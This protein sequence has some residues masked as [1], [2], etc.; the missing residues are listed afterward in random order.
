MFFKE[1]IRGTRLKYQINNRVPTDN[2][3]FF[4]KYRKHKKSISIESIN[5]SFNY[6]KKDIRRYMPIS[7]DNQKEAIELFNSNKNNIPIFEIEDDDIEYDIK[8]P[9]I[10]YDSFYIATNIDKII[11]NELYGI[12]GFF[13]NRVDDDNLIVMYIWSQ[14]VGND[15]KFT[16][17]VVGINGL[18][19]KYNEKKTGYKR[20]N[21]ISDKQLKE[22]QKINSFALE[23]FNSLMRKL[24]YKI[25][26]KEYTSYKK[27]SYGIFTEKSITFSSDVRSH[28]RHFWKDSGRFIIPTLPKEEIL[29]RGYKIDELV[30]RD[31]KLIRDVPYTIISEFRIGLEKKEEHKVYSLIEKRI[32]K[33][34]QK[35]Y[36]ILK[37]LY[38]DKIIR[39]HDRRTLKGLELD[40]NLPELRIGIE[41]DG[42]QHFDRK[43]C[44]EVFKSSF[45]D[46]VRRDR[47]KDQLCKRKKITLIRIKYD[48]PLTK[49][50]I[51]NKI[52]KQNNNI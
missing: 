13:V 42:E 45:D 33:S 48:E 50:H 38:P 41:Y 14:T 12:S 29:R 43:L 20:D 15:W 52:N 24:I 27:H 4:K 5:N 17:G 26:K 21:N 9:V 11:D 39:R 44:E 31:G 6:F 40:F 28:K 8:F 18:L 51:K 2:T 34:E 49:T 46:Q 10:P 1:K 37:E 7:N 30:L 32:W 47:K 23:K 22:E 35:V 3:I 19:K 25:N 16:F 36:T